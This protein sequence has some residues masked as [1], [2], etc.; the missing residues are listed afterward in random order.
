M[1]VRLC[2]L[3]LVAALTSTLGL[4]ACKDSDADEPPVPVK[5]AC[6]DCGVVES[7]TPRTVK[8]KPSAA[9]TVLGAVAGGVIGH[10]IGSGRGNDAATVAGAVGGAFAGREIESRANTTT[11]FDVEVRMEDGALRRVTVGSA[12]NLRE[13]DKVEVNG[14]HIRR[15]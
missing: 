4:S 12:A 3:L 11:V 14:S 6:R 5:S 2:S 13:G 7:I 8:G 9:G 10:Q 15:I 1:S